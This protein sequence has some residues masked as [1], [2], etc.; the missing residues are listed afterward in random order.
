MKI[1]RV[2]RGE[3]LWKGKNRNNI[4]KYKRRVKKW[5]AIAISVIVCERNFAL[6]ALWTCDSISFS[7]HVSGF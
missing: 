7:L 3:N 5:D 4:E 2:E 6:A 1:K